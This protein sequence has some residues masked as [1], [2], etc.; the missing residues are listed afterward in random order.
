MAIQN[1]V[2]YHGGGSHQ[3]NVRYEDVQYNKR[4]SRSRSCPILYTYR[5]VHL[6]LSNYGDMIYS[7][8]L[9][10]TKLSI[11]LLIKRVFCSVQRDVAYWVTIF[12]IY[13][14]TAFYI[15]FLIVPA[16]ECK[17]RSK[18]WTPQGPGSCVN[19]VQLYLASSI[20]NLLSDLAMLSVPVYLVWRLQM[21]VRRKVGISAIFCTGG[22]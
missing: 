22:L 19:V 7:I 1:N 3:W 15:C 9:L 17:P 6:Q 10:A 12:L 16:A 21:S 20:F 18:I 14:N 2:G 13:A 5:S 4:V 11:M 8:S